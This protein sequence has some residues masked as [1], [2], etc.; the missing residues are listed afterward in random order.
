MDQAKSHQDINNNSGMHHE[1]SSQTSPK[2][3]NNSHSHGFEKLA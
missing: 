3:L 1:Y 2:T